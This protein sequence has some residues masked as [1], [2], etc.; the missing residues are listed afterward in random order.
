MLIT[1]AKE[2]RWPRVC[3]SQDSAPTSQGQ[4]GSPSCAR[5][6]DNKIMTMIIRVDHIIIE[7]MI[8]MRIPLDHVNKGRSAIRVAP[9]ELVMGRWQNHYH[10][11]DTRV[12]QVMKSWSHDRHDLIPLEQVKRR[13]WSPRSSQV[14]IR[15]WWETGMRRYS[16]EKLK[17]AISTR[18]SWYLSLTIMSMH[19]DL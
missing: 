1:L 2:S 14:R 3:N 15:N 4:V 8:I 19:E 12:G 17:E 6:G 7:I 10:D 16:D 13:G 18:Y 11:H 5:W 9:S